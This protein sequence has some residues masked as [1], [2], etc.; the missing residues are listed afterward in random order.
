MVLVKGHRV[1][2]MC[3]HHMLPFFGKAH[4]A[5]V[6]N[7]SL[8]GLSKLAAGGGRLRTRRLQVQ[9]RLTNDIA[10]CVHET[11]KRRSASRW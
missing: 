7:G 8:V 11:L 1:Y 9:E 10:D 2:S 3:E 4:V 6:P 5:Y